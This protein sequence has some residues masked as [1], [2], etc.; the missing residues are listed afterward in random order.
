MVAEKE[1]SVHAAGVLS[2]GPLGPP[3]LIQGNRL[4]MTMKSGQADFS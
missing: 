1:E 4:P 3:W 2:H